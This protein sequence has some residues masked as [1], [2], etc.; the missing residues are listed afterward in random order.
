MIE[1]YKNTLPAEDL[2]RHIAIGGRSIPLAQYKNYVVL[3]RAER[4]ISAI[5]AIRDDLRLDVRPARDLAIKIAKFEG[6]KFVES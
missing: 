3:I 2:K 4:R 5:K 1:K 6:L